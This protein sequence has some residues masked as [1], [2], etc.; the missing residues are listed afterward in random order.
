[1]KVKRINLDLCMTDMAR[2]K[3]TQSDWVK[4]DNLF[5]L[6]ANIKLFS[7]ERISITDCHQRGINAEKEI[8]DIIRKMEQTKM[9]YRKWIDART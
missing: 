1:M 5:A 2:V 9:V 7:E 3:L 6:E 8:N 4:R